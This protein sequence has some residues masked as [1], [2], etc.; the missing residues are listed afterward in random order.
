[1]KKIL[2]LISALAAT[3]L[4]NGNTILDIIPVA[5]AQE[6][7]TKHNQQDTNEIESLR[8]SGLEASITADSTHQNRSTEALNIAI[9]PHELLHSYVANKPK[10][11]SIIRATNNLNRNGADSHSVLSETQNEE[12][13]S[14][15]PNKPFER[16][17]VKWA[18]RNRAGKYTSQ[19]AAHVNGRL[20]RAGYYSQ[21]HAY[22]ILSRFPSVINGYKSVEIP[23][24]S[25]LSSEK[26]VPAVLNMHRQAA[27]YVKENLDISKLVPGKYYVV[28]MYY[29]TS[30]Y[31]LQFF[32]SA[33]K[34][35]TGNY[36]THVG[37]LYYNTE[38][39]AWVVEHNIHGHVYYDALVSVLGGT[40]NPN[41]YG[42]TSI[43]R[44][45]K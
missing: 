36:G 9:Q 11:D 12:I 2:V 44:V 28:N 41:K 33:R 30:P 37:V 27:D 15:V 10:V 22:Q 6:V 40:S 35:G 19:C 34:Q 5:N 4:V 26:R 21:G 32:Y 42:I 43:S 17:I 1:M 38:A 45:S 16:V 18:G 20:T 13:A 29:T 24:L 25:K 23:N 39:E 14:T 8:N 7:K 31:M 3:L